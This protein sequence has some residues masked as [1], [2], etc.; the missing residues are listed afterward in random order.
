MSVARFAKATKSDTSEATQA[1]SSFVNQ[2]GVS[3]EDAADSLAFIQKEGV[4]AQGQ[5]SQYGSVVH[6]VQHSFPQKSITLF[7]GVDN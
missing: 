7:L 3:F 1:I 6:Y 4:V 2:T 5:L